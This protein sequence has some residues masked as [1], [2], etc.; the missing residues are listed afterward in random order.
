MLAIGSA[1]KRRAGIA[2]LPLFRARAGAGASSE[3]T[4]RN[5][6]R[7]GILT[8]ASILRAHKGE[9]HNYLLAGF[10]GRKVAR[11]INHNCRKTA[12]SLLGIALTR[13]PN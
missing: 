11:S 13:M 9:N 1:A 7:L 2:R 3:T 4:E 8:R 5:R 12:G 6:R 10:A